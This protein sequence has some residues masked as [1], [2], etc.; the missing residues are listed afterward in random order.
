M[1]ER[2]MWVSLALVLFG[3]VAFYA[4]GYVSGLRRGTMEGELS[5]AKR[6][7]VAYETML[8]E[9]RGLTAEEAELVKR[10]TERLFKRTRRSD[11]HPY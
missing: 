11:K 1:S 2:E 6:Q 4:K 8:G 5:A 10:N 7:R 3:F 9:S